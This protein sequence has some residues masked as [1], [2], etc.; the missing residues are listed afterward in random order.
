MH[1]YLYVGTRYTA[2]RWALFDTLFAHENGFTLLCKGRRTN[3]Y[4]WKKDRIRHMP[5]A[6]QGKAD[7]KNR[8]QRRK[9][10]S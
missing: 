5:G 9:K 3:A 8:V 1:R 4:F 6:M 2:R 10:I 7:H